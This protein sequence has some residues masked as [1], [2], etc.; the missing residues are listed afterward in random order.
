ML[1][2]GVAHARPAAGRRRSRAVPAGTSARAVQ[3]DD[4][5]RRSANLTRATNRRRRPSFPMRS[6]SLKTRMTLPVRSKSRRRPKCPSRRAWPARGARGGPCPSR[7][8]S[9]SSPWGWR[10][11]RRSTAPRGSASSSPASSPAICTT[12]WSARGSFIRPIRIPSRCAPS[13]ATSPKMRAGPAPS[14]TA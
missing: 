3:G 7:G 13:A 4:G 9:C 5:G 10:R 11:S 2:K 12:P 1:V 8:A 14:N 6:C